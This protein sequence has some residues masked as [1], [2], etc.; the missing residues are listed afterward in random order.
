[1]GTLSLNSGFTLEIIFTL[2]AI[3]A[4]YINWFHKTISKI[5]FDVFI[6]YLIWLLSGKKNTA[7]FRKDPRLVRRMA[8]MMTIVSI[9]GILDIA[10]TLVENI[11]R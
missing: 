7:I 4:A 3:Y 1:M 9:G 2:W 8:V 10:I 5:G 11:R 6:L